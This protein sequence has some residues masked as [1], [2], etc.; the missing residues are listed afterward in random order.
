MSGP[1]TGRSE[2]IRWFSPGNSNRPGRTAT[3][4]LPGEL[5]PTGTPVRYLGTLGLGRAGTGMIN[6]T[7]DIRDGV[8]SG[9]VTATHFDPDVLDWLTIGVKHG[10]YFVTFN[11]SMPTAP[12]RYSFT[13]PF[14]DH[15]ETNITI[16]QTDTAVPA[17]VVLYDN[18]VIESDLK[19][20]GTVIP[21]SVRPYVNFPAQNIG[22]LASTRLIFLGSLSLSR[23][24]EDEEVG[25][26]PFG[27]IEQIEQIYQS[28]EARRRSAE[29]FEDLPVS[30]TSMPKGQLVSLIRVRVFQGRLELL[31]GWND[32]VI[33][34]ALFRWEEPIDITD[35]TG[36][37]D[38][39][40]NFFSPG[41]AITNMAVLADVNGVERLVYDPP[42]PDALT[43]DDWNGLNG[44]P[45]GRLTRN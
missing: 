45:F 15:S 20:D 27:R 14:Q 41:I 43:L 44:W 4:P 19:V 34:S 12:G 9:S 8:G 42:N 37:V 1:Y 25:L 7:I 17:T 13:V 26:D 23:R 30:W 11:V 5:F 35:L 6:V 21:G 36:V 28:L 33:S 24:D 38:I 3:I 2:P 18:R 16:M 32:A 39:G 31:S 29:F 22:Q 10:P 40:G